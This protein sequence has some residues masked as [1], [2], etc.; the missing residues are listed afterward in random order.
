M[1]ARVRAAGDQRA[2]A[3][4]AS[5]QSSSMA[6]PF[7]SPRLMRGALRAL[8]LG[9]MAGC[10]QPSKRPPFTLPDG[11]PFIVMDSAL[12]APVAATGSAIAP[13]LDPLPGQRPIFSAQE[14]TVTI[15]DA[16]Y[17]R[18]VISD[19]PN[20]QSAS[21]RTLTLP[22]APAPVGVV[23]RRDSLWVLDRSRV[24][25]LARL[26][27]SSVTVLR[28]VPLPHRAEALCATA[29]RLLIRGYQSGAPL[30]HGY[31]FTGA[32]AESFAS[33]FPAPEPL[34]EA[35]YA[36]GG[37]YCDPVTNRV[38]VTFDALAEWR[39]FDQT[40][41]PV[42]ALRMPSY[43]PVR[44]HGGWDPEPYVSRDYSTPFDEVWSLRSAGNGTSVIVGAT[45][46]VVRDSVILHPWERVIHWKG[47]RV[48]P[49]HDTAR[50]V[51]AQAGRL[52]LG[53]DGHQ[54]QLATTAIGRVSR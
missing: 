21:V 19:H 22:F 12:T 2:P 15:Y 5:S 40:G 24:L 41:R 26:K 45:R 46:E 29:D 47:P 11:A 44:I 37:L 4:A 34:M 36:R 14:G 16:R 17:G 35:Q 7:Q 23:L 25:F 52:F 3:R 8:G 43:Q 27:D 33:P 30:V 51:L 32:P 9:I 50:V 48:G 1:P 39:A 10:Q 42:F 54:V 28:R 38:V 31:L 49:R 13:P 18:L 6:S 20:T 53:H